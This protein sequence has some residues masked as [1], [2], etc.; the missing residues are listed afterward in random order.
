MSQRLVASKFF[1]LTDAIGAISCRRPE[2]SGN[3]LA[4]HRAGVGKVAIAAGV[5]A[6]DTET[7][8]SCRWP[9]KYE[10]NTM[11][12]Q[13]IKRYGTR[14][15]V[16]AGAISVDGTAATL[17]KNNNSGIDKCGWK[18]SARNIPTGHENEVVEHTMTGKRV[19]KR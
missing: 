10:G 7:R 5:I 2:V 4:C 17:T 12:L 1:V 18:Y 15:Q 11:V 19:S 9:I 8:N 14:T 6:A 13:L 16:G 3:A